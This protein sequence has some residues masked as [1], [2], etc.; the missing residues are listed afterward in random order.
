[1]IVIDVSMDLMK[2]LIVEVT[3]ILM[4]MLLVVDVTVG[5]MTYSMQMSIAVF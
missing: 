1:M 2:I 4:T 5:L 3:M